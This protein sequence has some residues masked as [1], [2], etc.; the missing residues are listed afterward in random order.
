MSNKRKTALKSIRLPQMNS[1]AVVPLEESKVSEVGKSSVILNKLLPS[2]K[3]EYHRKTI[4]FSSNTESYREERKYESQIPD[5]YSRP[6][7][8]PSSEHRRR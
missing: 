4:S 5:I 1:I 3:E 2:K 8:A 7:S 6:Q